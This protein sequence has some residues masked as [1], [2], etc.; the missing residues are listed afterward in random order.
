[1]LSVQALGHLLTQC[2]SIPAV[3]KAQSV[4]VVVS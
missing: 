4:V 1:M 2:T 3:L